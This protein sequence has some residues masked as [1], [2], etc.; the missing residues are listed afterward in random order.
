[1]KN[2]MIALDY[3]Q[4]AGKVA[5]MGYSLAKSVKAKT[6]LFHAISE[7]AFY[8]PAEYGLIM[9]FPGYIDP[10]FRE[11]NNPEELK[12]KSLSF[13]DELKKTPG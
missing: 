8:S 12:Q 13:L 1:M 9:G 11:I 6:V 10:D 2:V 3:N 7:K 4:S 5:K